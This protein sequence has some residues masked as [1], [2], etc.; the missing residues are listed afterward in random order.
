ML[1]TLALVWKSTVDVFVLNIPLLKGHMIQHRAFTK[2]K[3]IIEMVIGDHLN[4]N[5]NVNETEVLVDIDL[6]R[7]RHII[8]ND[9]I[10]S[11]HHKHIHIIC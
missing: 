6:V 9:A 3:E 7:N 1:E 11:D 8:P 10:V 2:E 5:V 4:E